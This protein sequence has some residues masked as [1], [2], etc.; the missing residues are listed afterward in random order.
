M[1]GGTVPAPGHGRRFEGVLDDV[2]DGGPARAAAAA[3][4]GAR[5]DPGGPDRAC[6]DRACLGVGRGWAAGLALAVLSGL[7]GPASAD[8]AGAGGACE[9]AGGTYH[10]ALPEGAEGPVPALVFLHGWGASG[11]GMMRMG[12]DEVATARG[13]AVIAPDGLPRGEG[14]GGG[15]WSFHPERPAA[16]DEAAFLR[17]VVA[18]ASA[19]HGVDASRV[20]L[21]GF[22]IGGS[23][24]SYVA[25]ASPGDFAAYAPVGGSF[26]RPHPEGCAGPVRLLHTHGWR[27]GTVPL[28]GR[29]LGSGF[30]QGDVFAAFEIWREANGCE[31]L[32]AD[33]FETAGPFWRRAWDACAPGT[34]LE[35]ALFDGGH[36]VPEGWTDL[37]LDWFEGL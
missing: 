16:R 11:E 35:L 17:A 28:E 10:I 21:S 37:A 36:A 8:C 5:P 23:M 22:S 19:R 34:A 3:Q 6:L 7:A 32:R 26:W 13:Y 12:I 29:P 27:D 20:I 2:S 33:R 1:K 25:C 4:G 15:S 14:Q 30:I 18:D 24:A 31:G 9:V